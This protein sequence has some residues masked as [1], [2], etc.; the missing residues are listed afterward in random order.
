MQAD[1]FLADREACVCAGHGHGNVQRVEKGFAVTPRMR[2]DSLN[3]FVEQALEIGLQRLVDAAAIRM[4]Q[5]QPATG[6][7]KLFANV[8]FGKPVGREDRMARNGAIRRRYLNAIFERAIDRSGVKAI[9]A[10]PTIPASG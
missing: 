3:R 6:R 7:E 9:S 4:A 2:I 8:I 10:S 5:A 1:R